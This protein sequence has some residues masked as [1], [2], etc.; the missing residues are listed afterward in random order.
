MKKSLTRNLM[1][2]GLSTASLLTHAQQRQIDMEVHLDEPL[3]G[4]V[5]QSG[6]TVPVTIS[7]TNHGPDALVQDDSIFV[8]TPTGGTIWGPVSPVA[9]GEN[10]V[11]VSSEF[12][13]PVVETTTE[14][15]LCVQLV[16]DP[17]NQV[18]IQGN[19]VSVSY[20]DPVPGNNLY[21]HKVIVEGQPSSISKHNSGSKD[22]EVYP[23]PASQEVHI[24]I[25]KTS[26]EAL[27]I[28][29]QDLSGKTV[30]SKRFYSQGSESIIVNVGQL[31][32]GIYIVESQQGSTRHTGKLSI[33]R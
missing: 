16:D 20:V 8:I 26:Q 11:L 29:I 7:F 31:Q 19:Q 1:L 25:D 27:A 30:L 9:V 28:Q 2:L 5:F 13:M 22:L 21:C 33:M 10:Y 3:S 24:P 23:N 14:V 12:T 4:T 6:E 15:E 17:S 32:E 18:R